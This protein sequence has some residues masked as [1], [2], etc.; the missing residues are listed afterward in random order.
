MDKDSGCLCRIE[1][2]TWEVSVT[3]GTSDT[4]VGEGTSSICWEDMLAWNKN[5]Q[6]FKLCILEDIPSRMLQSLYNSTITYIFCGRCSA[7]YSNYLTLDDNLFEGVNIGL[8][9][10]LALFWWIS[11]DWYGVRPV[12]LLALKINYITRSREGFD[13]STRGLEEI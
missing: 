11:L 3:I 2:F 5:K 13:E 10:G 4:I 6:Y 1:Q 8:V 9:R 12:F 7:S